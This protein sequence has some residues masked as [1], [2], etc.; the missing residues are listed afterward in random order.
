MPATVGVAR[1]VGAMHTGVGAGV[2]VLRPSERCSKILALPF[3][4]AKS[5][6]LKIG[7]TGY[8]PPV[9]ILANFQ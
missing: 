8:A 3:V 1:F 4:T 5:S 9:A 7:S 6:L 2:V